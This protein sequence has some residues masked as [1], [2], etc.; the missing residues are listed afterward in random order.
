MRLRVGV[1]LLLIAAYL[2]AGCRKAAAPN[3]DRNQPPETWI[4]AAPLDTIGGRGFPAPIGTIP[5]RFHLYW[6]GSGPDGQVAG[7]F[8]AV[9]E[10]TAIPSPGEGLPAIPGPKP[11][12][13]HFTS[14]SDSVFTFDVIEGRPDRQHG[15]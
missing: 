1:C 3:V 11:L 6:A 12:D 2:G 15:F 5:F 4:T 7:F 10:T 14:K 9:T 13:Y 8:F